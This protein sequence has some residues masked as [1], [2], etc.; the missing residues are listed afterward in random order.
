MDKFNID[1][2]KMVYHPR[3]V[4]QWMDA[5]HEWNSARNVYPIYVEISP[6]GA[7][8]HRCSFCA[9]DYI[10]YNPIM[11]DAQLMSARLA[12][13]GRLGVKSI[14]FAGEGEPLL[15]KQIATMV[16]AAR[17]AGIDVA[18]TSNAVAMTD[19]V[20]QQVLPHVAWFKT[21]LNAGSAKTY[22]AVHGTR[23][24]DFDK[25]VGN[26]KKA[27]I[28]RREGGWPCTLGAQALLL[29]ENAEEMEQLAQVCRDEIGLDYLVIKPYS[30]EASS[31]TQKYRDINYDNYAWLAD[32][33]NQYS[34]PGFSVVFRGYSMKKYSDGDNGRYRKCLAVP[35]FMAYVATN[36]DVYGCKD[37]LLD[38]RFAY[39]NL[40][41]QGFEEIWTG[42]KRK[43]NYEFVRD[44]LDVRDCRLNCRMD[45]VNRYLDGLVAEKMP[46]VNF[47]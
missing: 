26:L 46:H 11:L 30:H 4:A 33:V 38:P 45:E 29:P 39:G 24:R 16:Q 13:M 36:G 15:H 5:R 41:T 34:R 12:E 44:V 3:R 40:N 21:S 32:R 6:V 37:H 7:C 20:I 42:K 31:L 8:N 2:H 22:A 47:I 43:T 14:M 10:G 9:V 23:E 28:A 1:A 19:H 27:V 17:A 18:F 25:V 35:Y